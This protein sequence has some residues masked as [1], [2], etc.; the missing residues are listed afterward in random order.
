MFCPVAL[1]N[2]RCGQLSACTY[3]SP[4][5]GLC[6]S[7]EAARVFSD[8][9]LLQRVSS[10]CVSLAAVLK[11]EN[12]EA[13]DSAKLTCVATLSD[14]RAVD[15]SLF[16]YLLLAFVVILLISIIRIIYCSVKKFVANRRV[17]ARQRGGTDLLS[18]SEV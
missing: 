16:F 4:G 12:G 7:V 1:P 10:G 6:S 3:E 13:Y 5:N 14:G 9:C 2:G 15:T 17:E 11:R 18:E 8:T